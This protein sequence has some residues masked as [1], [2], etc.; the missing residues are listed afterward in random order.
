MNKLNK[1]LKERTFHYRDFDLNELVRLKKEKNL[2]ISLCFPTFN[3]EKTIGKSIVIMKSELMDRYPLIDEIAVVDSG[4][5]D[6][7]CTIAAKF[8]AATYAAS[9]FLKE[10][11]EA[12]GKGENLW[13][14]LY[15][16]KGD[17]IVF[18]D[19]DISN[20]HHR[21][22]YGLIGP[23]L[24]NDSIKFAKAFYNRPFKNA[25]GM[26]PSGGGR[27]TEI[28]IRPLFSQFFPEL[29]G[30]IQPL[31]GEY[32][33]YRDIFEQISFPVGYGVETGML[34]D[35][36]KKWGL[37]TIAQTNLDLRVHRNQDI[38]S[39][40]KMSFGILQ[41]FW[42][43]L[44]ECNKNFS[45][46]PNSLILRQMEALAAGNYEVRETEIREHERRPMIEVKAYQILRGKALK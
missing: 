45:M 6:N 32:A 24:M 33:G 11:G 39:L 34:I 30:V 19:A 1:W 7:T 23:L 41:I 10:E 46:E 26:A 21:F 40:G 3:E 25:K 2:K 44:K 12:R 4:S 16:L 37:D 42:N 35:I 15:L 17:I 8:G 29:T 38:I 9:D 36:Y 14:A 43:R 5:S 22:A 13:K 28:L 31:S 27:V 20:I 18:V